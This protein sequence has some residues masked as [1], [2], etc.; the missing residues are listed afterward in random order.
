MSGP[1]GEIRAG[2]FWPSA[3]AVLESWLAT[4][5]LLGRLWYGLRG[6]G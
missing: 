3:H 1:P 2:D 5:E 4:H 6:V